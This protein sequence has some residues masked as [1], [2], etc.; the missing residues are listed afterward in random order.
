VGEKL[1]CAIG[2]REGRAVSNSILLRRGRHNPDDSLGALFQGQAVT[3]L[4][5]RNNMTAKY[6]DQIAARQRAELYCELHPT[7][8]SAVRS[9][10]IFVR[11]GIWI[12][13]LG[14]S[15]RDGIAGFGPTIEAAL[16]AF[17]AQYLGAL[18]DRDKGPSMERAA[19]LAV[20]PASEGA[21][22]LKRVHPPLKRRAV[23]P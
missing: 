9:P 1:R 12:A 6:L 15:V 21:E 2:R 22:F 16:R 3:L 17:D 11:S 5:S 10:R 7:S 8:P 13:L 19:R 18:R 23:T 14:R 4:R 20:S